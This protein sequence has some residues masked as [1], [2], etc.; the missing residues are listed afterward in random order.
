MQVHAAALV[1][2]IPFVLFGCAENS[3]DAPMNVVIVT[4]DT[5]RVDPF[6]TYGN[7][8]GHTPALDRFA[9]QATVFENALTS[10]GTT[11]PA[12]ASLFSGTYPKTHGVRWNG[13]HVSEDMLV[14]AEILKRRGYATGAFVSKPRLLENGLG[15]GF[16]AQDVDGL[17]PGIET[18]VGAKQWMSQ[19]TKPFF[20]WIHYFDAHSPYRLSTYAKQG[21]ARQAYAGPYIQGASIHQFYKFGQEIPATPEE[22]DAIR[23]LYDGEVRAVDQAFDDLW[24]AVERFQDADNTIVV[25][26]ADHGQMLGEH[27][28]VGHGFY[29][30]NEVLWIPLFIRVPGQCEGGR[31]STRVGIVDVFPT[32]LE[33]LGID[34]PTK[35]EGRSL[36]PVFA[37]KSLPPGTYFAECRALG[38]TKIR[39]E[40]EA[41][42]VAIFNGHTKGVLKAETFTA[43]DVSADPD[44]QH[45]ISEERQ[46]LR[47][48]RLRARLEQYRPTFD[49]EIGPLSP[50]ERQHLEA[51]GY[52]R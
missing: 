6:G 15:Q 4:L 23:T 13:D 38:N 7:P 28:R 50:E 25:V 26:V 49:N 37:G 40:E 31:V 35:P 47:H 43:Y 24:K 11:L 9:S 44:E 2:L 46:S 29:L 51:L 20:L 27:D 41:N 1:S 18:N 32:V 22:T 17:R 48:R 21:F 39:T 52:I 34:A 45:P 14:L 5:M 12:H 36:A 3:V 30:W 42:A 19:Q 8:G 16:D 33:L 10:I